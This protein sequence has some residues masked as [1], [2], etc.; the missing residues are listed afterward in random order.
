MVDREV[1]SACW[2]ELQRFDTEVAE[3]P[4]PD[5]GLVRQI[6]TSR[7]LLQLMRQQYQIKFRCEAFIHF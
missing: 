7:R 3:E 4:E 2:P 1:C 5:V 6:G